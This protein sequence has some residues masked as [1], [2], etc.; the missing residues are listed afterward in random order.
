M[1]VQNL[2][3]FHLL[4]LFLCC[5]F[6]VQMKNHQHQNALTWFSGKSAGL[7]LPPCGD[8]SREDHDQDQ[9]QDKGRAAHDRAA[10][11]INSATRLSVAAELGP[12]VAMKGGVAKEKLGRTC[13]FEEKADV[14]LVGH[15]DPTVH[16]YR[17]VG[18]LDVGCRQQPL[19]E[20]R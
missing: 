19:G 12:T 8:D 10:S 4:K 14:V 13:S 3:Q 17:F 9:N 20:C 6:L 1:F 11:G 2:F 15:A 5:F 16:L 18:D 7:E